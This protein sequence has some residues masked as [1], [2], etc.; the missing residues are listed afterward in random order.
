MESDKSSSKKELE[1]QKTKKD[2]IGKSRK[3]DSGKLKIKINDNTYNQEVDAFSE[4]FKNKKN[5][6]VDAS[7][8]LLKNNENNS[9]Y[10]SSQ[11]LINMSKNNLSEKTP[12]RTDSLKI[13][14]KEGIE[15]FQDLLINKSNKEI[16]LKIKVFAIII[17]ILIL[18]LILLNIYKLKLYLDFN[19]SYDSYFLDYNVLTKRISMLF[20]YTNIFRVLLIFP[21]DE[22]KK[23]FENIMENLVEDY[24]DLNNKYLHILSSN[25]DKYNEIKKL[26]DIFNEG[27]NISMGSLQKFFCNEISTCTKYLNSEIN[28]FQNGIDFAL[29]TCITQLSN[30]YMDYKRLSNKTDINLIKSEITNSP[31]YKFTLIE[32]SIVYMFNQIINR[33]FTTF[34]NDELNFNQ[35]FYKK[36]ILFNALLIIYIII[37]FFFINFYV[38]I[39]I[40]KFIEPI[41]ES[42]YRVNL[43]FFYIK[44]FSI[45]KN[46]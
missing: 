44:K 7:N 31:H 32:S 10:F 46:K 24:E 8:E 4:F 30:F 12:N 5:Q 13:S 17:L 28:I 41:K 35:L 40:S 45:E 38:F 21:M 37:I 33:I 3:I 16:I 18:V 29:K 9:N 20:Y 15:N 34:S 6:N 39:S 14:E 43:S 42:T 1:N 22:R 26:I 27:S 11:N 23:T 36:M 2:V 19:S 25:T